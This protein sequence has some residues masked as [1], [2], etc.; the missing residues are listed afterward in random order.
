MN[1]DGAQA[2]RERGE[3]LD[4]A[5][6]GK[7]GRLRQGGACTE[8]GGAGNTPEEADRSRQPRHTVISV[9]TAKRVPIHTMWK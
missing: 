5:V 6:C 7:N 2:E 3:P 9:K 1:E 4:A 8:R